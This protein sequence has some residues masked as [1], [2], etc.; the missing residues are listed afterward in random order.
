MALSTR[1]WI[2]VAIRLLDR[3]QLNGPCHRADEQDD[4]DEADCRFRVA[5]LP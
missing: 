2:T 5:A 3:H 1:F 4:P